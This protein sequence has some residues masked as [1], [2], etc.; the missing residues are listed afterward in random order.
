[1]PKESP[2]H[3]ATLGLPRHCTA[4]QIRSAYRRLAKVHHPDAS[5]ESSAATTRF[6]E[7]VDAYETLSD[8]ARRAAYEETL[9]DVA[10][11]PRSAPRRSGRAER[12]V[13]QD[14][15][16]RL[17]EFIRGSVREVRVQDPANASGPETYEL[18]IPAGTAPGTRLKLA[19]TG[20]WEGGWVVIR[21]LAGADFRFKARGADLR[22]DLR[23]PLQRAEQGGWESIQ[24]VDG[25][26]VR[27]EIPPRI[28][29][30]EILR[31]PGEGLPRPRGGRGD[32]LVRILYRPEVRVGPRRK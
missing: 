29:R 5:P 13:S 12:N 18:V 22:C 11:G 27:V 14:V 20:E 10:A 3:Y 30:G 28:G 7:L 21:V 4:A 15:C 8:P 31:L 32:L 2:D 26:R 24:G 16:L 19:R 1:L 17:E 25:Q 23:I 9:D 6:Q